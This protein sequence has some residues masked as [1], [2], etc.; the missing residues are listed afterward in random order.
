MKVFIAL[1]VL[2]ASAFC[3]PTL[4][5]ERN[6]DSWG[7]FKRVHQKQYNSI[8]E[9]S[10]RYV[11]SYVEKLYLFFDLQSKY[12]GSQSRKNSPT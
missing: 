9:E 1:T 2:V 10:L 4:G 6:G 11:L 5:G 12:L 7:L 8:G 3:A